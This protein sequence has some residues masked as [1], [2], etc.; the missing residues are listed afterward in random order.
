MEKIN[1]IGLAL[2]II[3]ILG[4][5]TTPMTV[6]NNIP[7]QKNFNNEIQKSSFRGNNTSLPPI[8][9][10]SYNPIDPKTGEVITFNS[11]SYDPDGY[12]LNWTWKFGDG[13]IEY[14]ENVTHTYWDDGTYIVNLT[15]MD[16]SSLNA[17]IEKTIILINQK[18][19]ADF[20][21]TPEVI[22]V[23]EIVSFFDNTTDIDGDIVTWWW[24]F[25]DGY[26]SEVQNP[27]HHYDFVGNYTVNLTVTDDDGETDFVE[28]IITIYP[29]NEAPSEPII[30]GSDFVKA[31]QKANFIFQSQDPDGD[32]IRYIVTWGD[33]TT[34]ISDYAPSDEPVLISHIWN[35]TFPIMILRMTAK[36]EDKQGAQSMLVEKWVIINGFNRVDVVPDENIGPVKLMILRI[37]SRFP[38]AF[39]I[40]RFL[41]QRLVL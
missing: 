7:L 39:P 25:G 17:S 12:I 24:K 40:M 6:A 19:I 8:A 5:I 2:G 9:N 16:N 18:P 10:F 11:N 27:T 26:Y 31:G 30:T 29:E 28:K 22:S 34:N 1:K 13:I 15:V 36:A 41:L 21:Y 14:G 32:D 23:L 38:N 4:M 37:L 35:I 3:L 20:Y 33:S